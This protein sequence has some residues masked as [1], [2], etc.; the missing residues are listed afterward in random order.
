MIGSLDR[1]FARL[2]SIAEA[3]RPE[4]RFM[5]CGIDGSQWLEHDSREFSYCPMMNRR[6]FVAKTA[7]TGLAATVA[8][9]PIAFAQSR[10]PNRKM[11]INLVCG[12]LGIKVKQ[13][14]AIDLAHQFGF[15]SVEANG[16]YLASL[17]L[18]GAHLV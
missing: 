5:N 9:S 7:L 18:C 8:S 13:Q 3:L 4:Y 1:C 17:G 10:S 16:P 12:A 14:E 2:P 11:T 15:E 6:S